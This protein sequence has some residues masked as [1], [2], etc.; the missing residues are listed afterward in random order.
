[1]LAE[2]KADKAEMAQKLADALERVRIIENR[3]QEYTALLA[4]ATSER[5]NALRD[6]Q[7]AYR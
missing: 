5:N 7:N 6:F 1:M 4:Q 2:R 3:I